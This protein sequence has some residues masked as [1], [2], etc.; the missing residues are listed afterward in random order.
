MM[1]IN[2]ATGGAAASVLSRLHRVPLH[3]VD[4][5]AEPYPAPQT[6]EGMHWERVD[7]GGQVGDLIETDAMDKTAL[8]GALQAGVDAVDNLESGTNVVIFG[9][10]GIGN[11]TP[12]SDLCQ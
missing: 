7:V 2:L 11:T 4:V 1:V 8:N 9:E 12:A 3:V 6:A 5:G 10:M